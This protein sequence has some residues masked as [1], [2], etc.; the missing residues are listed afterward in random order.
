MK[1]TITKLVAKAATINVALAVNLN[2][3]S[4]NNKLANMVQIL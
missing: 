3:I 1:Y 2:Q 4:P